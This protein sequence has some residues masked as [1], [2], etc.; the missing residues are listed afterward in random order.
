M[1]NN[2][3]VRT[4]TLLQRLK[5]YLNLVKPIRVIAQRGGEGA[6]V[7]CQKQTRLSGMGHLSPIMSGQTRNRMISSSA[8]VRQGYSARDS[9]R[10]TRC[11]ASICRYAPCWCSS[12]MGQMSEQIV[13][14]GPGHGWGLYR[15]RLQSA[16]V[17][18]G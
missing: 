15:T 17:R 8:K 10:V 18:T 11:P 13:D 16:V 3:A 2:S 6:I 5:S 1:R 12:K 4:S 14:L 9:G 7:G